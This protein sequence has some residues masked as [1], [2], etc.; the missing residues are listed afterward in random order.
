MT[1]PERISQEK[2]SVSL[3]LAGLF[4]PASEAAASVAARLDKA[5]LE[6]IG[7]DHRE[8]ESS[9]LANYWNASPSLVEL[10]KAAPAAMPSIGA[11]DALTKA[12]YAYQMFTLA[13]ALVELKKGHDT[14]AFDTL[15]EEWGMELF[16]VENYVQEFVH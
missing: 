16:D 15:L 9:T 10:V 3:L 1:L 13:H 5:L 14:K 6:E 8:E 12:T 2:H 4:G 7:Y 11:L